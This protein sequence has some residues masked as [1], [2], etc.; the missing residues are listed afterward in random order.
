MKTLSCAALAILSF[1][2]APLAQATVLDFEPLYA[3][4]MLSGTGYGGLYWE[5]GNSGDQGQPGLWICSSQGAHPS[6]GTKVLVNGYG[7][8]LMGIRF[9]N[10]VDVEGAYFAVQGESN[11]WT[12]AIRAHGYLNGVETATTPWLGNISAT[13]EWL[14]MSFSGVNRIVI[15][16]VPVFNNV[17][18]WYG[19]DDLTFALVPEPTSIAL[20]ALGAFAFLRRR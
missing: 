16:S 10:A 12:P 3:N 6:S 11:G 2:F 9:T 20:L 13:P 18:G 8:T 17:A 19:M 4:Q 14:A 15:E 5:R 1:L 7:S